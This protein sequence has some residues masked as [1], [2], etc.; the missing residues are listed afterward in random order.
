MALI[1]ALTDDMERQKQLVND[2]L[3]QV[4]V[5]VGKQMYLGVSIYV[6]TEAFHTTEPRGPCKLAYRDQKLVLLPL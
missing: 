3:S 2:F 4:Q 6:A 5:L 1:G